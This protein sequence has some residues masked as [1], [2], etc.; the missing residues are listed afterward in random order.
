MVTTAETRESSL[1]GTG[2]RPRGPAAVALGVVRILLGWVFLWTFLDKTFG[3]GFAT[4]AEKAWI[5][6]GS[7]TTGYLASVDGS[8]ADAFH[9]MAAQPWVDWAFMLGMLLV[10][11]AL[12]L[13]VAL[14]LAAVGGAGLMLTLWLTMVPLENNPLGDQHLIYATLGLV[15]AATRAGN[16]LGA[17]RAWSALPVIRQAP[18][19]R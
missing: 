9:A 2:A 14:R 3:L 4:P 5:A 19:L 7:P 16:T 12:M 8:F 18:W 17:G 13:G 15:L 6:G 11:L 1:T 10:G